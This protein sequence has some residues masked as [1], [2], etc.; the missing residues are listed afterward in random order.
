MLVD[1]GE[2]FIINASSRQIAMEQC[3]RAT[4]RYAR[5]KRRFVVVGPFKGDENAWVVKRVKPLDGPFAPP[6]TDDWKRR[7]GNE[8]KSKPVRLKA[9]VLDL[10]EGVEPWET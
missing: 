5:W 2:R 3:S 6:G 4:R 8:V 9:T 1:L 7:Q 10:Y